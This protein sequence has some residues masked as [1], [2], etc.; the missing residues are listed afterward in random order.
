M[1]FINPIVT[2]SPMLIRNSRLP[3]ATP[4]KTTPMKL[5]IMLRPAGRMNSALGFAGILLIGKL[6]ELDVIQ[7]A[8]RLLDLADV[9]R[10]HDVARF[11]VDH[12]RTTG[13]YEL[14]ALH[15]CDQLVP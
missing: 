4:S 15:R 9:H 10:L 12:D 7:S 2:D 6:V 13:A 5:V 14:H 8:A 1:K 11:R 3:Y